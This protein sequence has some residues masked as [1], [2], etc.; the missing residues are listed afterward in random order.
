MISETEANTPSFMSCLTTS[1][2][3]FFMREASSPTLISSGIWTLS[4]CFLAISSWRRF[5]LSRSSCR[6][7]AEEA[8]GPLGRCFDLLLI[9]SLLPR[10][11]LLLFALA[12]AM[13]SNFS[14]YFSILTAAPPRVSTTRF[15]AT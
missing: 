11:M 10:R 5:I 6:R 2:A 7:L 1:E 13:S 3:V 12:P 9:F 15:S 4:G 14:L 8:C